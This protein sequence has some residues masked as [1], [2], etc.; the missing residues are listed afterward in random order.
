M[1]A[2]ELE[3]SFVEL[4]AR[5]RDALVLAGVKVNIA[6]DA[7]VFRSLVAFARS[8]LSAL[9]SEYF[10]KRCQPSHLVASRPPLAWHAGQQ[11]CSK[12]Q[13]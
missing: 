10:L 5:G 4:P 11:R 1:C 9:S 7:D 8:F 6:G 12:V 13:S 3:P 2:C